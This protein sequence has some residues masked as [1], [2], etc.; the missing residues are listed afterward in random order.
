M[1]SLDQLIAGSGDFSHRAIRVDTQNFEPLQLRRQKQLVWFK[2]LQGGAQGR[3]PL[4]HLPPSSAPVTHSSRCYA[5]QLRESGLCDFGAA[6]LRS[7]LS[8]NY[9]GLHV[10]RLHETL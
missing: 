9:F 2:H 6:N 3:G 5:A 4:R 8:M 10:T 1:V 7:E